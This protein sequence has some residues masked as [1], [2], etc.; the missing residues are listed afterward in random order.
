[1]KERPIQYIL[2]W[3]LILFTFYGIQRLSLQSSNT[4]EDVKAELDFDTAEFE[5]YRPI[6]FADKRDRDFGMLPDSVVKAEY[7]PPKEEPKEEPKKAPQ[8]EPKEQPKKPEPRKKLVAEGDTD[9]LSDKA[10]FENL[11]A[12]YKENVLSVRRYRNDVVVRYYRHEPDGD[13]AK[14]LV[15]YGFYLHERPVNDTVKYA[16]EISNVIYYGGDFPERDI[17]L[18]AYVLMQNGIELKKLKPF[19]DYTGWKYKSIEIGNDPSLNNKPAI[20]LKE[21]REFE[22]AF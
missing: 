5:M 17:K 11:I 13:K 10:Y 16:N 8:E 14:A 19:K 12:S 4:Y 2:F 1:M 15:K 3:G 22:K 18:I 20:T 7:I 6:F 21:L 9:K